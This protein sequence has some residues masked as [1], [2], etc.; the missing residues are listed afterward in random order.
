MTLK[1]VW[2]GAVA[3][4]AL[5]LVA[6]GASASAFVNGGFEAGDAS[7]W[8]IGGGYRAPVYNP[9]NP[10]D[11]MPGGTYYDPSVASSHSAIV[12]TSSVDPNLGSKI[13]S[14]VYS[15]KY[16]WRVEDT[17][18]GGYASVISQTVTNYTDPTI[19]FEWKSVLLGAH[20]ATEAATMVISLKDL[21]SGTE[22][23]HREYNAAA[24][25]GGVDPRFTYD[26]P[27]GNFYT[28][29][30]QIESLN[31]DASLSGHDFMLS[32]LGSDCE[33]TAHWGYVYLDGFGSVVVPPNNPGVPEPATL[34]L[35]GAAF[36]GLGLLRRRRKQA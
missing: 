25:G 18:A 24:G 35:M 8:T 19:Y 32:V 29:D 11:F 21:T 31:I 26:N 2:Q 15:G 22:L 12:S 10:A 28:A 23:I 6:Q 33:P 30:W 17:V 16:A 1:S 9:P 5:V 20:D 13:G 4:G 27:T 3:L 34:A 14:L 36:A 7:G